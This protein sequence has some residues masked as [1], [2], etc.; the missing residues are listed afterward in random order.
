[1]HGARFSLLKS[2]FFGRA[3]C[4]FISECSSQQCEKITVNFIFYS[5]GAQY[6]QA[7][8]F[9][10]GFLATF[11]LLFCFISLLFVFCGK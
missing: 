11:V 6:L 2:E 3:F 8:W 5:E 7:P 1:M 9:L 4:L 10:L